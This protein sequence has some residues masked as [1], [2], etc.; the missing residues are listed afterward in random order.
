MKFVVALLLSGLLVAACRPDPP[1]AKTDLET[2]TIVTASG[3]H[4]FH[5]EIADTPETQ[6]RGLMFRKS[7]NTDAGMLFIYPN[8][9]MITMWMKN[10][11][12]PLDMIFINENG[13]ITHIAER[14]VP[15]STAIIRSNGPARAV[16][17]VNGGTAD[18]LRIAEG[19]RVLSA[20]F[21]LH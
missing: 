20:G 18:R 1:P 8:N 19:D 13:R 14:T 12:I 7:L 6:A 4:E 2:L 9:E 11:Y 16:L 17:E 10:T 5:I 21:P 15:M 3:N